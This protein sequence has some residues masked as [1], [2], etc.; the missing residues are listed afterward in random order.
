MSNLKART[1]T[2]CQIARIE[3]DR[4]N[5]LVAAGSYPCAPKTRPGSARVFEVNDIVVLIVYRHL[6][7]EG[8]IPS[9]AGPL[10]CALR[11]LLRVRPD[12]MR[13]LC[14][15]DSSG[16]N[17]W[18]DLEEFD[19]DG[20]FMPGMGN[21]RPDVVSLREWRLRFM[22]ERITHELSEEAGIVGED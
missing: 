11:D 7:E 9:K 1:K 12:A 18:F 22:R 21:V 16:S 10:A 20:E 2:A 8:T 15:K 4:F 19:R 17:T 6:T 13:V 3:P 14:V 5:E